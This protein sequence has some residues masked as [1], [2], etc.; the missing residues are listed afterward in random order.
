ML[1]GQLIQEWMPCRRLRLRII[2]PETC[3][4]M[5]GFMGGKEGAAITLMY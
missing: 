2:F 1:M 3:N 5:L 4:I